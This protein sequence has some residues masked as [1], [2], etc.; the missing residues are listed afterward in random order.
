[1]IDGVTRAQ[2][3]KGTVRIIET[4]MSRYKNE[5]ILDEINRFVIMTYGSGLYPLMQYSGSRNIGV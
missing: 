1:M 2:N 3:C 4:M 5:N